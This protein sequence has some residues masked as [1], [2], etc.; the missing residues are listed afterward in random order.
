MHSMVQEAHNTCKHGSQR[1]TKIAFVDVKAMKLLNHYRV[2]EAASEIH[3]WIT[4][5]YANTPRNEFQL[6]SQ[7]IFS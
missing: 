5:D 2:M 7:F 4:L 1:M 6:S 3:E